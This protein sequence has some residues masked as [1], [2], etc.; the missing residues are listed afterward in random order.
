[1][2]HVWVLSFYSI[3][4]TTIHLLSTHLV[5]LATHIHYNPIIISPGQ[6]LG[7]WSFGQNRTIEIRHYT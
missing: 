6:A 7:T 4:T 3:F 2:E 5:G 1:M